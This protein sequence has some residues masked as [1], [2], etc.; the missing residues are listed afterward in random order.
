MARPDVGWNGACN[1]GILMASD[2]KRVLVTDSIASEAVGL[3]QQGAEVDVR[4]NLSPSEL[5]AAIGEYEALVVRSQTK[6][7][8]EVIEAGK[9][10]E[11]IARAGVGVDNIDVDAATRRGILV[12]NSPEG[13]IVSAAEHTMAMLLSLVRQIPRANNELRAGVWNRSLKGVE[14][15]N[16]VLGIVG[17]G[18]VGT[19]VAEMAR[20]FHMRVI[21]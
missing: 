9:R 15:R 11:V 6:V 7:T 4:T 8:G 12:I 5:K 16:K 19:S 20:G 3:L 13:N 18:R 17:F 1:G 21:A 14:V 10:L 2:K